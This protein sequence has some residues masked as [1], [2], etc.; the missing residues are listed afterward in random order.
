MDELINMM[1]IERMNMV[2]RCKK[3]N[4][5]FKCCMCGVETYGFG[6]NPYP[7]MDDG[8]CCETCNYKVLIKRVKN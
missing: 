1:I 8:R 5:H 3:E 4:I 7:V 2:E 6:N